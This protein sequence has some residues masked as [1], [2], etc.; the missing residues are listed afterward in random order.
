METET[1]KPWYGRL[2]NQ[3]LIAMAVGVAIGLTGGQP[4]ADKVG[5]MGTIFV[6]ALK[7]VIVPLVFFSVATGVASV[8]TG[9]DLGRLGAKTIGY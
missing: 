3:V 7:M 5:W 6:Q 8:G 9:R 1:P 2:H 4:A